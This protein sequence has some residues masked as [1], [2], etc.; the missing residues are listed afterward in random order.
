MK[1]SLSAA[2]AAL[3]LLA[4]SPALADDE[5]RGDDALAPNSV[6]VAG[7]RIVP[8]VLAHDVYLRP[9]S[10]A[11][12]AVGRWANADARVYT[13]KDGGITGLTLVAWGL[14][15]GVRYAESD[16]HYV[17]W[18][19]DR[20]DHRSMS[21]GELDANNMGRAILGF[22]PTGPVIGFDA[23]AVTE[24][25]SATA[26]EPGRMPQLVADLPRSTAIAPPIQPV[27]E[28]PVAPDP[29]APRGR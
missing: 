17:V 23:I 24:E 15:E 2:M 8:S 16:K 18:L 7:I 20:E 10:H 6:R 12:N 26:T 3:T 9:T 14:P 28:P 1:R 29:H 27:I 25:R 19:I 21:L 22:T 11:L 13:N 5:T 4:A